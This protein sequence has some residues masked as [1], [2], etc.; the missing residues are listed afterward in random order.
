MQTIGF[1]QYDNSLYLCLKAC[2][3]NWLIC[4]DKYS[5]MTHSYCSSNSFKWTQTRA[6]ISKCQIKP[7]DVT[8]LHKLSIVLSCSHDLS[9]SNRSQDHMQ[10]KYYSVM[11][12]EVFRITANLLQVI[13]LWVIFGV[14]STLNNIK[15]IRC[16]I[17]LLQPILSLHSDSLSYNRKWSYKA[18]Y[19]TWKG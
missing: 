4:I 17:P 16:F 11:W 15:T 3:L 7:L 9:I 1:L 8:R 14:I 13:H 5:Q 12:L 18:I 19:I 10:I 6:M 2:F